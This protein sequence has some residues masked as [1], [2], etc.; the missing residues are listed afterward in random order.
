MAVTVSPIR[1][2]EGRVVGASAIARDVGE[3]A[4]LENE[5]RISEERYRLLVLAS[6]QIA[7]N[8]NALKAANHELE[9]FAYS[10]SHDL[11]APL[12]AI[13]GSSRT[14]KYTFSRLS[15]QPL[16]KQAVAPADLVT[17]ALHELSAEIA[18]RIEIVMR[19]LPP[20]EGRPVIVDAGF[21]QS[22][23]RPQARIKVGAQAR[24][25][26]HAAVY[27]LADNGVGFDMRYVHKLFGAF[28]RLHHASGYPGTGIGLVTVQR[29]VHRHCGRVWA[30]AVLD[31][32]AKSYFTM[33]AEP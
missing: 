5:L 7:W 20:C 8:K 13:Y 23:R 18:H 25:N 33:E 15:R 10:V 1:D 3:R 28:Q 30:E 24:A 19:G 2:A 14:E 32:G 17:Q 31:Q 29:I 21:C 12:R 16:K 4:A 22:S 9:A 11:R 26:G 6:A 27:Y